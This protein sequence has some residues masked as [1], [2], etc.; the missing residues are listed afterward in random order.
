MNAGI[1]LGIVLSQLVHPGAPIA[2]PVGTAA[3]QPEDHGRN[4]VLADEQ[5]VPLPW[6]N[7]TACP[8]SAWWL[9]RLQGARPQAAFE[10]TISLMTALLHGANIVHDVGFM[11]L[12][13]K[14]RCS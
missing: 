4:Y 10:A 2:V 14:A 11:T 1:L 8:S 3:V 7:I 13:C 12:A 9:D 5:G 6:A